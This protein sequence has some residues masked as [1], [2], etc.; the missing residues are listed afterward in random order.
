MPDPGQIP[1]GV[2]L[3]A[4]PIAQDGVYQAGIPIHIEWGGLQAAIEG[5]AACSLRDPGCDVR[6]RFMPGFTGSTNVPVKLQIADLDALVSIRVES[7]ASGA[8]V[9]DE[10]D[11]PGTPTFTSPADPGDYLVGIDLTGQARTL[12]YA[13]LVRVSAQPPSYGS[14]AMTFPVNSATG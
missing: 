6:A 5:L 9:V 2:T 10:V 4:Q 14:T 3:V 13:F 1:T 7:V 8:V 11:Q 12:S